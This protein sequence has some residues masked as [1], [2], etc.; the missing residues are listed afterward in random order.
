MKIL[1]FIP[2]RGGS[3][4]I[5]NKNLY[6][7]AG[8]KLIQYTIDIALE[9]EEKS[10]QE[11]QWIPFLSSDDKK[12]IDYCSENGLRTDYKRPE[13]LSRD[14]S[15]IID[16]IFDALKWQEERDGL[17]DLII[18]LQ[19]TS[20]IRF[21]NEIQSAVK[22]FVDLDLK[23]LIS[24]CKMKEHPFECI[25]AED[26]K[27]SY[28]DK[29]NHQ[30]IGRQEYNQNYYFI[31]GNFYIVKTSFLLEGMRLVTEEDTELFE[32]KREWPVDIDEESDFILAES[33]INKY[34]L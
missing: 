9:L 26:D 19:P 13:N 29:P 33:L 12:I 34:G 18:M 30:L 32:I 5:I 20:P 2:A 1:L 23:S 15:S 14:D 6:E 27:W 21:S 25:K 11:V 31:D 7:L 17:P 22:R 16:G 3:K 24:V 4:G 28:I 10:D 8:K